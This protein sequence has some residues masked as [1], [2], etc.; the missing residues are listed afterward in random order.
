[1][2]KINDIEN[3][4]SPHMFST[5]FRYFKNVFHHDTPNVCGVLYDRRSDG[6]E[7]NRRRGEQK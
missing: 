1:M 7:F 2:Q 3:A 4:S 5:C 6:V